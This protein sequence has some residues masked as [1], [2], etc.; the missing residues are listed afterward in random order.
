MRRIADR[1]TLEAPLGAGGMGS[2]HRARDE[3]LGTEVA[4]KLL[5]RSLLE[6]AVVR[7][8]FRREAQS[9][10]RLRHPGIVGV[11]DSGEADGDLYTVL[12]LVAGETLELVMERERAM[13]LERALPIF[14]Q[15]LAALEVCHASDVVHRDLKP[16]NVMVAGERVVLIDF[17]LARIGGSATVAKLTETGAVQGTPHYMAPEQCRGE[18]VGPPADVY[19]AGILFYEL[20]SGAQPFRGADAATFMAQ[21]LFV[22]PVPLGEAAPHVSPGGAAAVHAALAKQAEDRPTA[23]ELRDALAAAATGKDRE[24]LAAAAA[25]LRAATAGLA[26][27]DR[28]LAPGAVR[29]LPRPVDALDARVIVWVSAPER[30]AAIR[31]CLATA[32]LSCSASSGD[33]TPDLTRGDGPVTV[34]VSARDGAGRIRRLRAHAPKVPVV[35]VDVGGPDE[36]TEVI[37]AGADDMLLAAAPDADL[38]AKLA[39]LAR[40]RA[41]S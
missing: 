10:A 2:I 25:T 31:G 17:G 11:F 39:R 26:R 27:G 13:T 9:L 33:A 22:Q 19:S 21:H 37:R 34:V 24:A 38:V 4:I 14:D 36:T 35:V 32:G 7:E 12:E 40:R 20:L 16:S 18:E 3:R 8:R 5:K 1:Y 6:D 28:A 15:I 30:S 41:R 23:R 29:D